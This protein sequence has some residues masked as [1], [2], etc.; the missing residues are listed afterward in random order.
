MYLLPFKQKTFYTKQELGFLNDLNDDVAQKVYKEKYFTYMN[1]N[2]IG[3]KPHTGHLRNLNRTDKRLME[4]YSRSMN[5]WN[6]G[7]VQA[8][9]GISRWSQRFKPKVAF[10]TKFEI[11][12]LFNQGWTVRDLSVRFGIMPNRVKAIVY[13]KRYFFNQILPNTDATF[14]QHCM[15]IEK[16]I[17]RLYGALQYGVDLKRMTRES[18]GFLQSK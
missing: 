1:G 7:F 4:H 14:I 15:Q 17:D 12:N 2:P 11:F 16:K 3:L 13:Q 6:Y 10:G 8:T 9:G 18:F 5:D